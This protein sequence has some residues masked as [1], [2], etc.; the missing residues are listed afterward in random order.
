MNAVHFFR[1]IYRRFNFPRTTSRYFCSFGLNCEVTSER[2]KQIQLR[3]TIIKIISKLPLAQWRL[4]RHR[5]V[6]VLSHALTD[7]WQIYDRYMTDALTNIY[8]QITS[9]G[10]FMAW[11]AFT[12]EGFFEMPFAQASCF[13]LRARAFIPRTLRGYCWVS[14][15]F[16][17]WS[18]CSCLVVARALCARYPTVMKLDSG[19]IMKRRYASGRDAEPW[20]FW[21]TPA[22]A[23]APGK[24]SGS[25]S[26]SE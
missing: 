21:S 15:G 5:N 19:D 7:I 4:R 6:T 13:C 12:S 14:P 25:G 8:Q 23:P 22:P 9:V 18:C 11:V 3:R 10:I 26:D 2:R 16:W 1:R 24:Q 17:E 20:H